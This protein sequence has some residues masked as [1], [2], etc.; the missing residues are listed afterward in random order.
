MTSSR[1]LGAPVGD[2]VKTQRPVNYDPAIQN[3]ECRIQTVPVVAPT[4]RLRRQRQ[5]LHCEFCIL[6]YTLFVREHPM[7]LR[8]VLLGHLA[9]AAHLALRLRRLARQDVPLESG[10]PHDLSG[11]GLLEALGGAPVRLEFRHLSISL[12]SSTGAT[13]A[14]PSCT[15]FFGA[16]LRPAFWLRMTCIWLPSWRGIVSA[17]AWSPRSAISRSRMRRPISGCAISRPRKKIVALTLS[18][19]GRKRS[20]CFFLKS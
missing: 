18:P 6:H 2:L 4:S 7:Q 3:S 15:A 5:R 13:S 8:R 1:L 20:M 9:G 10:C 16:L 14:P 11:P 12:Y 17:T 19:S